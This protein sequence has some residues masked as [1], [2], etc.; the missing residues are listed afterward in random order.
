MTVAVQW[1][2]FDALDADAYAALKADIRE[3]GVLVPVEVDERG[4]I[5]DG[6]HRVRAHT[7]LRAEGVALPDYPSIVR[8]GLDEAGKRRHVI[9]LNLYRRHLTPAQR[10]PFIRELRADGLTLR[11]IAATA[12]VSVKTVHRDLEASDLSSAKSAP[13]TIRNA[14]GQRRPA[15]YR[16]RQLVKGALAS[17]AR[18]RQIALDA[19]VSGALDALPPGVHPFDHRVIHQAA[20]ATRRE[21][22]RGA[23]AAPAPAVTVPS[24]VVLAVADARK[25]PLAGPSVE[26]VVTSP[27]Y[28]LDVAYDGGDVEAGDW[29]SFMA[30]W[31]AEALRVTKPS[32]RLALNVPL[33]TTR[34]GC[35][36][37]YAQ[38]VDAAVSV[39]WC[40]RSTIV[41]ADGE[42]GKSTARGSVDSASSPSI[43]APVELVALFS[44]GAWGRAVEIPSDLAHADWVDWTNGLWRFRGETSPWE[45]HPAPFPP[46]LP[47]RLIRLLSFPGETVLDPFVGSGTT[48]L[49]ALE[50]GR[51]AVGFDASPAYLASAGRRILRAQR[52]ADRACEAAP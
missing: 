13:A 48:A 19:A 11:Q 17:S 8:Y 1:Q 23:V 3:R 10:A 51:R 52:S 14:R 34:G 16:P 31:L 2:L 44:K 25:L 12:G 50:L 40:Y 15:T 32:G 43:I 20:K 26:L 22:D 18:Q 42:L 49:I 39:G 30:E 35:R 38:A 6:H 36:P 46:E 27:P 5:L 9:A 29:P 28:S 41:W 21:R 45:G 37:T 47:R 4:D 33:D 7:E 24:G